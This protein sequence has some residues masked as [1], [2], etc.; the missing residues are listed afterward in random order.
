MKPKVRIVWLVLAG[1]AIL[2]AI[3]H[4]VVL[5]ALGWYLVS[6][7]PPLK[8]DIGLV[9]AG[10]FVGNRILKA[11]ALVREGYAPG[12][13]VSGPEGI[14]GNY[15][16]DLAIPF[17]ERAGYPQSYFIHFEHHGLSTADEARVVV[18]ELRRR[19]AKKVLLV[20]SDYHTRRA[21]K[22]F[23][24]FA[25]DIAFDMV[26]APDA[27]FTAGGWWHNREGRKT[28]MYEWMKTVAEWLGL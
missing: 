2:L 22:I 13:L 12:M 23:R 20:T 4:G 28:F 8:A 21:G 25:P 17:A 6:A 27:Y 16:C 10:D 3:F 26:A 1:I 9:L 14:Y 11:G 18:P 7:G 15:E 24:A 5:G 19:G